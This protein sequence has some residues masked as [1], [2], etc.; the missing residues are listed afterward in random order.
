[1]AGGERP[2]IITD[3]GFLFLANVLLAVLLAIS[4][5]AKLRDPDS[6]ADAFK[7]LRLPEWMVRVRGPQLLPWAEIVL[8]VLLVVARGWLLVVATVAALA[9]TTA[10]T[11]IIAR[12]LT[13]EDLVRCGCFGSLGTGDVTRRTVVRNTLL[14]VLAVTGLAGALAG[15]S[16]WSEPASLWGWV[17]VALIGAAAAVLSLGGDGGSWRGQVDWI[18]KARLLH[19]GTGEENDV[20]SLARKHD[21]V[22]LLFVL[23]G[24]SACARI[25]RDL[26]ELR[27]QNPTRTILPVASDGLTLDDKLAREPDLH[28]DPSSNVQMA[29]GVHAV[30]AALE[31][32]AL[33]QPVG[34]VVFGGDAVEQLLRSAPGGTRSTEAAPSEPE[35]LDYI[36]RP[37]PAGIVIGPDGEPRTLRE[38]TATEAILLVLAEKAEDAEQVLEFFDDW[39]DSLPVLGVRLLLPFRPGPGLL[40]ER[41]EASMV[42]DHMAFSAHALGVRGSIAAVLLGADGKLAGGP[43]SGLDEVREF[44]GDIVHEIAAAEAGPA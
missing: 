34:G 11:I 19:E 27:K 28:R 32:D 5:V 39:Q 22:T 21:G 44:V 23:P 24:C 9:L 8:A 10:Y 31:V 35:E 6:T 2:A 37:I 12:A 40:T 17:A 26:P 25:L 16:A 3:V 15:I 42:Y 43:V 7:A 14:M 29:L 20:G 33:A 4:G 41:Q 36:R 38:L 1:M 18:Y 13:F 30:P